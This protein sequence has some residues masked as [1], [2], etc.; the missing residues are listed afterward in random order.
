MRGVL[1]VV[2]LMIL[3]PAL[4]QSE[5]AFGLL[6]AINLNKKL[7]NDFKIN[8]KIESRQTF[9]QGLFRDSN[10]FEYDYIL[11]DFTTLGAKKVGYNK[12]V[13][14]GYLLR[15]RGKRLIHR[16]IQQYI[17]TKSLDG[18]K[19]SHRI[20][21]DQTF[22][23]MRKPEFRLRYR[24]AS[25]IALNGLSVDPGEFYLKINNEYLNE[26]DGGD[27]DLEVRLM[28]FLGYTFADTQKLELGL[29]YRINS[30][31]DGPSSHRFWIAINYYLSL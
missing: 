4:G 28:P 10:P 2:L 16:S 23:D 31:I 18:V 15:V 9:E 7:E 17:W 12:T 5:Y 21:T 20:A 14:L 11:T 6:P 19:L 30:F 26:L 8:F 22:E 29:D 1:F 3:S 27:Y 24:L 13:A 25:Q